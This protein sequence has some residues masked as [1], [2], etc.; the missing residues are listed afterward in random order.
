MAA[1]SATVDEDFVKT[2]TQ[3]DSIEF[4]F[5]SSFIIAAETPH[6]AFTVPASYE[7]ETVKI[8]SDKRTVDNADAD[9]SSATTLPLSDFTTTVLETAVD[10]NVVVYVYDNTIAPLDVA[11]KHFIEV[12]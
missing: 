12:S 10:G 11:D 1:A 8:A 4:P 3:G 2:L 7:V 5:V 9:F 6:F